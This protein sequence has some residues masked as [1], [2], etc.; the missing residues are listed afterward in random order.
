MPLL[1]QCSVGDATRPFWSEMSAQGHANM[2]NRSWMR[3][4]LPPAAQAEQ[5]KWRP[6]PPAEKTEQHCSRRSPAVASAPSTRIRLEIF[7]LGLG[8]S[9][10]P[11]RIC[12]AAS[13]R[14]GRAGQ[15]G[16]AG[17]QAGQGGRARGAACLSPASDG[18]PQAGGCKPACW[19]AAAA[20]SQ[21]SA[22]PSAQLDRQTQQHSAAGAAHQLLLLLLARHAPLRAQLLELLLRQAGHTK[23]QVCQAG[24]AL[25][26][27]N[28]KH[29]PAAGQAPSARSGG[30]AGLSCSK[31]SASPLR[32]PAWSA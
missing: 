18:A 5:H 32:A 13:R 29:H 16:W 10:R 15:A 22:A 14:A 6:L 30:R 2:R 1:R 26:S 23:R 17:G 24:A 27:S 11:C 28:R 7:T 3:R 8:G 21:R 20:A 9:S 4:P 12:G 19:Q 25:V 31:H